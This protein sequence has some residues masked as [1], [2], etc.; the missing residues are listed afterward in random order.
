MFEKHYQDLTGWRQ[1]GASFSAAL[2]ALPESESSPDL[3]K[4]NSSSL[5]DDEYREELYQVLLAGA[6][7]H[8]EATI[9]AS[10]FIVQH[11]RWP[12]LEPEHVYY[13]RQMMN[14]CLDFVRQ[15]AVGANGTHVTIF[16]F[17]NMEVAEVFLWM[18]TE[19]WL[20]PGLKAYVTKEGSDEKIFVRQYD[21]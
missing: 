14:G 11:N 18:M 13:L 1:L 4:P 16:P 2:E 3:P 8:A 10:I 5:N 21:R 12:N 17:P 19:W 6:I 7:K 20:D 9:R 15:I